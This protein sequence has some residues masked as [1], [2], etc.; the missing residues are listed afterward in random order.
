MRGGRQS[1]FNLKLRKLDEM[2]DGMNTLTQAKA[3]HR[4]VLMKEISGPI[5]LMQKD[6]KEIFSSP[7]EDRDCSQDLRL[8]KMDQFRSDDSQM[9][10]GVKR[11][12]FN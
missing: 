8:P 7:D 3:T 9:H 1:L 2:E 6:E 5:R 10:G 12:F 11:S 4:R